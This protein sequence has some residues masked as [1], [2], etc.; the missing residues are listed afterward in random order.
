MSLFEALV[1]GDDVQA[2]ATRDFYDEYFAVADLPAEFYLETVEHIFQ[3]NRLARGE[4]DLARPAGRS[5]ARSP[6]PAC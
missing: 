3:G 2:R 6:G 5:R 1:A 4:Y